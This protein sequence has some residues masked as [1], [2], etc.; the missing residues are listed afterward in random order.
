M[1]LMM[2]PGMMQ[3]LQTL[4]QDPQGMQQAMMEDPELMELVSKISSLGLG[5]T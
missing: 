1:R 5:G 4:M 2:Q 3:K